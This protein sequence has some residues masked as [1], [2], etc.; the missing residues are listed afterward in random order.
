MC[1]VG[2][3]EACDGERVRGAGRQRKDVTSQFALQSDFVSV[4]SQREGWEDALSQTDGHTQTHKQTCTNTH[5][6]TSVR[7]FTP[8]I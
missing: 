8:S 3:S 4:Q 7:Q 6:L 5:M 2:A 1:V